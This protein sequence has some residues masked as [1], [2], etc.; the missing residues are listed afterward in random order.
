MSLALT[1]NQKEQLQNKFTSGLLAEA[2]ELM[3]E[4]TSVP[5]GVRVNLL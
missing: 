1:D 2:Y 4:W 3:E 5:D